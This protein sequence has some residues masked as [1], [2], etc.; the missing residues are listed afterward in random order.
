MEQVRMFLAIALSFLVFFLWNIFFVEKETPENTDQK[1][2]QKFDQKTDRAR[3]VTQTA[4]IETTVRETREVDKK[5]DRVVS[6]QAEKATTLTST[7]A[8]RKAKMFSVDTPLYSVNISEERAAFKS[9]VLKNYREHNN[10]DSPL[11]EMMSEE[12]EIGTYIV[13]F[14]GNEIPGLSSAIF[15]CEDALERT[16]VTSKP[17]EL[18]FSWRSKEGIEVEKTYKFYPDSYIIDFEVSVINRAEYPLQNNLS[19]SLFKNM[20]NS[21][22]GQ[23]GFTGP[24]GLIDGQLQEIEKDDIDET[25]RFKGIVKWVAVQDRYFISSLIPKADDEAAMNIFMGDNSLVEAQYSAPIKMIHPGM[26]RQ[27]GYEIFMGPKSIEILQEANSDLEKALSFGWFDFISKP[28]LKLMNF[29]Y[30]L[31]PNYGIVIIIL[32]I[33]IKI[34]FWPLGNKSY[35]SMNEMKRLQPL[36]ADIRE[37]YKDDKKRMNE[38]VMKLYKTYK[39]NAFYQMLYGAIELRHAPFFGWITDLSAPDRLFDFGSLGV[40]IPLMEPPY[41]IPVLT[42][43][44]GGTM[45]IQ[46]KLQPP[47]GD[48]TQAKM[49][50]MMPI[51]FTFIFINFSSGLV[52]Y[53]LINNILSIAQQYYVYRKN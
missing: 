15:I 43:I 46:Q 42:I 31:I 53:W 47:A 1:V 35:K 50:M 25:S 41:G 19:V 32:T 10:P 3:D 2:G 29:L 23:Y 8:S 38:E 11:K 18:V 39:I 52:L 24:S 14:E 51:V 30:D 9:F 26:E 28:C 40:S 48:P 37:K 13:D 44:M 4:N 33:L 12:N 21:K 49:M 6:E 7:I 27:F 22:S 34:L 17:E 5:T 20:E 45:F 36:M 16:D